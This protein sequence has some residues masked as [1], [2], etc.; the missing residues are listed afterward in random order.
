MKKIMLM[1]FVFSTVACSSQV[2]QQQTKAPLDLKTVE[3]YQQ[4]VYS[5]NTVPPSQRN[6]PSA[7][8]EQP[9]NVSD[10]QP[11]VVSRPARPQVIVAP[12]IGYGYYRAYPNYW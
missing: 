2:A 9:L 10:H 11:K 7:N 5:G 1:A 4:N 6:Q 8:I 3:A 12:S